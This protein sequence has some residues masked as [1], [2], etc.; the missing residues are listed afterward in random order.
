[1]VE[2]VRQYVRQHGLIQP[3]DRVAIAVSGGADSVA[4]LRALSELKQELGIVLSAA[5]FHHGI[6]GEEADADLQ[7]VRELAQHLGIE[8]HSGAA[9]TP[10]YA[11]FHRLSLETAARELRYQW[12]AR[13]IQEN[14]ADK[15]A[16]AHTLDDQAETVLMRLLRGAGV[17]GLAGIFPRQR[18][19]HLIRPLLTISRGEIESYLR[20][21]GQTWREDSSN[22]D[23]NHTRNRVRHRLMPVLEHEF[24]PEIRKTLADVAEIARSD[25]EYWSQQV[26]TV[27]P[28]VLRQG[29]PTRSGRS[30]SGDASRTLSVDLA[31]LASLHLALQ[32]RVLHAVAEQLGIKLEFAHLQQLMALVENRQT[33]KKLPLPG[34][35]SAVRTFRELQFTAGQTER[36]GK[37]Y[38]Y[39]LS[40]PGEIAIPELGSVI[41]ASIVQNTST[42]SLLNPA[43]LGTHL[44]IRNWRP[45][46]RFYPAKTRAAKKIKELLQPGRLGREI[47]PRERKNWPVAESGGQ[48]VWVRELAVPEGL[49]ATADKAVLID[50]IPIP[51]QSQE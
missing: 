2:F 29:K 9:D 35:F 7:L 43:L 6:R 21:L 19:K 46:D 15:I 47:S 30:A 14:Q 44:T 16:T 5:H 17:R 18:E 42:G 37:D 28:Q 27:L 13:L 41:R 38:E 31:A 26:A 45:G 20:H 10:A 24:N 34:K 22:R 4:L 50:E 11:R 1:M 23:L 8:L 3:G 33:G 12:F 40:I 39:S 25:S 32:R 36:R 51:E 48:I 49:A